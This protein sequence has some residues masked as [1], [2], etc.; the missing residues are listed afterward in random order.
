MGIQQD[1]DTG[2]VL[3][4]GKHR[5]DARR[6]AQSR[7]KRGFP[8]ASTSPLSGR[9]EAGASRLQSDLLVPLVMP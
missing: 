1:L 3:I 2:G 6:E 5:R 4:A 8:T 7:P 9:G